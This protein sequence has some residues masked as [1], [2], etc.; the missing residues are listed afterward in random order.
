MSSWRRE[1]G[2]DT[3]RIPSRPARSR[4]ITFVGDGSLE[5]ERNYL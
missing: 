2:G 1:D 5:V 3:T 4:D